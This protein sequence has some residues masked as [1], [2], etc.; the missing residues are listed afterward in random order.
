M[1]NVKSVAGAMED[2]VKGHHDIIDQI[3][4]GV[5]QGSSMAGDMK[6]RTKAVG[7]NSSGL[8]FREFCLLLWPLVLLL[9]VLFLVIKSLFR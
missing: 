1:R 9:L 3:E 6:G 4:Q 2:E 5:D 8:G 7:R